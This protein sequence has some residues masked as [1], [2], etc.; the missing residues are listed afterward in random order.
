MTN[1]QCIV[2]IGQTT[3]AMVFDNADLDYYKMTVEHPLWLATQFPSSS[4]P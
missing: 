4:L 2:K 1:P 3:K